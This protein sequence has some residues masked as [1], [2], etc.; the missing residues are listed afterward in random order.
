MGDKTDALEVKL[1]FVRP[2]F[3]RRAGKLV[4]VKGFNNSRTKKLLNRIADGPE[5]PI[6]KANRKSGRSYGPSDGTLQKIADWHNKGLPGSP[7]YRAEQKYSDAA[8]SAEGVSYV[9][10]NNNTPANHKMAEKAHDEAGALAQNEE[11]KAYHKKLA[12]YHKGMA[13]KI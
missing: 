4:N 1:S 8:Q 3:M 12:A 9:A 6:L 2:H 10:L 5:D 7:E 11:D 13:V